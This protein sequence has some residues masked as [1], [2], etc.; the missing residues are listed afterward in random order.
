[1]RCNVLRQHGLCDRRHTDVRSA[2]DAVCMNHLHCQPLPAAPIS[3]WV[4]RPSF[5][6]LFLMMFGVARG[7][8]G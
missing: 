3:N 8:V 4:H 6:V 5:C 2:A 7:F 1:M